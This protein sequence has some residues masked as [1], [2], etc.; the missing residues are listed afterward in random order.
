M[1]AWSLLSEPV[2]AGK[3]L[4]IV[5][6]QHF[7]LDRRHGIERKLRGDPASDM[8]VVRGPDRAQRD[9]AA[10]SRAMARFDEGRHPDS[11]NR[12]G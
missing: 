3:R 2:G 7:L 5:C 4:E 9:Q 10:N 1:Q 12:K 8:R 6:R 11:S